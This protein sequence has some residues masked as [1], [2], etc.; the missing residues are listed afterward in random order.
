M[1]E[2]L[3]TIQNRRSIRTFK[4]EQIKR[5]DLNA[6]IEAGLGAPSANNSQNWHFTAIQNMEVIMKVNSWVLDEIEQSGNARLYE[7]T[8]KRMGN[9]FGDAP[10]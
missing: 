1:N 3:K 2:V 9:V 7:I 10:R 8:E 6:I 5:Q 4:N